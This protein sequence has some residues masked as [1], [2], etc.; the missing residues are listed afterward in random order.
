MNDCA[1]RSSSGGSGEAGSIISRSRA[2]CTVCSSL[3]APWMDE[4]ICMFA[5]FLGCVVR[6][7]GRRT[8]SPKNNIPFILIMQGDALRMMSGATEGHTNP[9]FEIFGSYF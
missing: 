7:Q 5:R 3:P 8:L 2:R 6:W 1:V 9:E 4:L